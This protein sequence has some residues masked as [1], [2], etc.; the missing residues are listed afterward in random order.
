MEPKMLPLILFVPSLTNS[1]VLKD[2]I[3]HLYRSLNL[4]T[5]EEEP[6]L[7]INT[8]FAEL[9]AALLVEKTM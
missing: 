4:Q 8:T 2:A 7:F 6:T 3:Q 1:G 5:A 9:I